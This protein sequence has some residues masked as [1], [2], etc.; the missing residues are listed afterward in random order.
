MKI[1]FLSFKKKIIIST[2]IKSGKDKSIEVVFQD[3]LLPLIVTY[4][5]KNAA[6]SGDNASP[7][8]APIL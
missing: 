6:R 3:K 7:K 1:F 8:L 5:R 2:N 4:V